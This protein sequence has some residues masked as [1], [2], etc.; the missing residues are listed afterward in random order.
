MF[1]NKSDDMLT[2][3]PGDILLYKL[4]FSLRPKWA[5]KET[6]T[7]VSAWFAHV[8]IMQTYVTITQ[9]ASLLRWHQRKCIPICTE[10]WHVSSE[11]L[12]TDGGKVRCSFINKKFRFY[13]PVRDA[14]STETAIMLCFS[15]W[16]SCQSSFA[17]LFVSYK[18]SLLF[19][20]LSFH[21]I[22]YETLKS[23]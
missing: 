17:G 12:C 7:R 1:E 4:A 21:F 6:C 20:V 11:T 5:Q 3:F 14:T 13:T 16:C 9:I 8:Y 10:L 2:S 18:L 15:A 22:Q 19:T 23:S